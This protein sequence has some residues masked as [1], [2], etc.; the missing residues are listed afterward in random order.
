MSP[1]RLINPRPLVGSS[2]DDSRKDF[3]T[4]AAPIMESHG[5]VSSNAVI[6]GWVDGTFTPSWGG[7]A[8]AQGP[9]SIA[10]VQYWDGRG[11]ETAAHGDKHTNTEVDVT[12]CVNKLHSW[13]LAP[14]GFVSPGSGL[15]W[16][17]FRIR[18]K[19]YEGLGLIYARTDRMITPQLSGVSL[20]YPFGPEHPYYNF[21]IPSAVVVKSTTTV[22]SLKDII[23]ITVANNTVCIVMLHSILYPA[24]DGY[25]TDVWWW[26]GSRF[27]E[28]CE[29]LAQQKSLGTFDVLNPIGCIKQANGWI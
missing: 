24:D 14:E 20:H 11:F 19:W 8:G 6:T 18:Q 16:T 5:I 1:N 4:N 21:L 15:N 2:F 28:F 25:D 22:Q 27:N 29:W 23:N 13:G 9:M 10:E 7:S 3:H 26:D 17:N 12:E